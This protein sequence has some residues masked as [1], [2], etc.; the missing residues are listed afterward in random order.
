MKRAL[1]IIA[2][3][4][5]VPV[6]MAARPGTEYQAVMQLNGQPTRWVMPDGGRSGVYAAASTACMPLTGATNSVNGAV[7]A[8]VL[9]MVPLVPINLCIRPSIGSPRW[10]GGCNITPTDENY[11]VPLPVGVP[12]YITPDNAATHLCAVS[13]AGSVTMS[14]W[15]A[16]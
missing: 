3:L 4:A 1:A 14:V 15:W 13:D 12:Q 8:N 5:V 11:G 10:D 2:A 6:L 16:Q 9:V 7:S